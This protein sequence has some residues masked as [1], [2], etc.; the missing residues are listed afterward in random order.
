MALPPPLILVLMVSVACS[1]YVAQD[2]SSQQQLPVGGDSTYLLRGEREA[3]GGELFVSLRV[4]SFSLIVASLH[5]R[6]LLLIS[7]YYKSQV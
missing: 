7:N 4:G 2:Y 1:V 5:L 6:L 3:G